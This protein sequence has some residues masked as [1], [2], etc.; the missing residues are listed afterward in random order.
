M[1]VSS[2]AQRPRQALSQPAATRILEADR[3]YLLHSWSAQKT[4]RPVVLVGGKG[5]VFWD[6][7]G[8]RYLDFASQLVNLNLGFGH[9][10][11]VRAIQDQ[12]AQFC[13]AA[14]EFAVAAR[15]EL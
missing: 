10:R 1:T 4:R 13:Y 2:L 15:S 9:P 5:A 11:V 3:R 12:A 7:D 14:P 6:A 8:K